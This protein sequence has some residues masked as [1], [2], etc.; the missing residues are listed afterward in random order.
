ME[1]LTIKCADGVPFP[2]EVMKAVSPEKADQLAA[3]LNKLG[4]TFRIDE[5]AETIEF[6]SFSKD[7]VLVA[8]TKCLA[9][10]WVHAF[11]YFTIFTDAVA[12]KQLD[13]EATLD[14]R[15]SD[16]LRKAAALLKWAVKADMKVNLA[17]R[18]GIH[19]AMLSLPSE[20]EAVFSQE[21]FAEDKRF[22]DKHAFA[23]LAFILHHELA[24]IRLGH[25]AQQGPLS[26][27]LE[28]AA[29]RM[30]AEWLLD[31][32]GLSP[33]E[34]LQRQLGI[35]IALG[36]LASLAVYIGHS[37]KTHPPAWDRLYQVLEQY[38]ESDGIPWAFGV[39]MLGVHLDNQRRSHI[40]F[41]R[42]FGSFKDGINYYID[43]LSR[44][45]REG[46]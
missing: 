31:F 1:I 13:P 42:E 34:L 11:A 21:D 10:L 28:K 4:I 6:R 24:H 15:S 20:L 16:R 3:L 32:P 17:N 43:V 27:E 9:R 37:S 40:D 38:V 33:R 25:T 23:A 2:P 19:S 29:D 44:L 26:I 5:D 45:E 7:K 46:K 8:G 30:A 12:L 39:T 14:L 36:W 18:K 41:G 22:A 35:V